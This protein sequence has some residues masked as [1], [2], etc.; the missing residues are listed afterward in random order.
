M[1]TTSTRQE[2]VSLIEL[3][4]GLVIMAI[5][6]SAGLPAFKLWLQNSQNRTAAESIQNGLQLARTEAV[7]RN[8]NVR[9]D[10]TSAAGLV[11]WN[12][13]CVTTSADCPATIQTRSGS[14]G[15]SN[16]RVGVSATAI[17]SPAPA[18][19]FSAAVSAGTGLPAGATFNGL[20][21]IPS[22]N[23]GTDITRIDI[24]NAIEATARRL[25]VTIGTGGTIRMC[26]P[27]LSLSA[28][29]QGCS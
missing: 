10:L 19:Q 7:R 8:T 25:V 3:M 27:A 11:T 23:I 15:T 29:P 14:E 2:G 28:N 1:L 6:L 5:L 24:T 4:I 21:R 13:G 16:A 22:A 26:D 20:G 12:V 18:N 9:F 17:P